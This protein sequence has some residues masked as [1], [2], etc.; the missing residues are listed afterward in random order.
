MQRLFDILKKQK[1]E[2][3]LPDALAGKENGEWRKYSS[4]EFYEKAALV[5]YGLMSMGYRKDD[6]MA[7]ISNNR[8]EW[9]IVDM[10]MQQAGIVD[11]PL[12]PTLSEAETKFILNDCGAKVVFVSDEAL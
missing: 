8:P 10:G 11:V 3:Q 1:E 4:Q 12:Y 2:F 5:S 7:I 9:N 6:K